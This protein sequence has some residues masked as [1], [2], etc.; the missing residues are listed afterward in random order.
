MACRVCARLK[1]RCRYS[2]G[3]KGNRPLKETDLD[4]T[5]KNNST[6][7]KTRKPT[8]STESPRREVRSSAKSRRLKPVVELPPVP[9]RCKPRY[10]TRDS[11]EESGPSPPRKKARFE[12]TPQKASTS[13]H[14]VV[15]KKPQNSVQKQSNGKVEKRPTVEPTETSSPPPPIRM[16]Q[17]PP[18]ARQSPFP[19]SSNPTQSPP[20]AHL[21]QSPLPATPSPIPVSTLPVPPSSNPTS[22]R[23]L[24]PT[25]SR[26][27][28]K[29]FLC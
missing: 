16:S 15:Q 4:D 29:K 27:G 9:T 14:R 12:S 20:P 1:K 28:R 19:P 23:P 10:I 13:K 7:S 25:A 3:G 17:S 8:R 22:L 2:K 26:L 11:S 18:P 24:S 21:P 5:R 6:T